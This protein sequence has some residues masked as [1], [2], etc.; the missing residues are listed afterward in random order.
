MQPWILGLVNMHAAV[1]VLAVITRGMPNFQLGLFLAICAAVY[2]A[3]FLNA[4][5]ASHWER[6][7]FTQNYFDERGVFISFAYS[8]PLLGA[9][10]FQMVRVRS[11]ACAALGAMHG[12]SEATGQL[13]E[14]FTAFFLARSS[15]LPP[16]RAQLYAFI[17]S[18]RLLIKVKRAEL[19]RKSKAEGTT[20]SGG[21]AS[22]P[23][24][25]ATPSSSTATSDVDTK[26]DR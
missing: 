24:G 22:A 21:E 17:S 6:L 3:Q 16:P 10:G 12:G 7:G 19:R 15:T 1:W 20:T 2:A 11:R 8:L 9:A 4:Y 5:G 18:S 14:V 26:K 25:D 13:E 23:A